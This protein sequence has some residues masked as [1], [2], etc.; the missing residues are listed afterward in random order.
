MNRLKGNREVAFAAPII[1]ENLITTGIGLV[2]SAVIGG[3]SGSALA[4]MG[5]VNTFVNVVNSSM[6]FLMTGST[7]LTARLVGEDDR[8][9]TSRAVEQA[10]LLAILVGCAVTIVCEALGVTI[11][12]PLLHAK[13]DATFAEGLQ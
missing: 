1:L 13:D 4:A 12:R 8:A 11:L 6:G 2:F 9:R 3:I 7:V 5:L 10:I